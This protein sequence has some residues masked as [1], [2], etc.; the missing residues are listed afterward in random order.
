MRGRSKVRVRLPEV[1]QDAVE[2]L[3]RLLVERATEEVLN[4]A[5][6]APHSDAPAASNSEGAQEKVV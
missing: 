3:A 4:R 5:V 2:R 6:D 1:N